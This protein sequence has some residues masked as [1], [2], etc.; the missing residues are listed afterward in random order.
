MELTHL[1]S[2]GKCMP[3]ARHGYEMSSLMRCVRVNMKSEW[4]CDLITLLSL[5]NN[6]IN[7]AFDM[8]M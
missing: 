5:C 3:I 2:S 7:I 1:H 4:K 6:K 8:A